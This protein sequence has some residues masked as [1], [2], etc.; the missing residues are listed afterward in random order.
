MFFPV[1]PIVRR[2][3]DRPV[4]DIKLPLSGAT[5]SVYTW[6]TVGDARRIQKVALSGSKIQSNGGDLS[7]SDLSPSVAVDVQA[8]RVRC[9]IAKIVDSENKQVEDIA[10]FIDS[11]PEPDGA[12]LD[13][14]ALSLTNASSHTSTELKK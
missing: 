3:M 4:K 13:A 1:G 9:L 5:V 12:L 11:L 10:G 7:L 8:E 2:Y 14:E 6:L